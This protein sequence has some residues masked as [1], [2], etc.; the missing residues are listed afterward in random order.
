MELPKKIYTNL[1]LKKGIERLNE[2]IAKLKD[3]KN[4]KAYQKSDKP[5]KEKDTVTIP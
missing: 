1:E 3:I 2:S 5:K 4:K